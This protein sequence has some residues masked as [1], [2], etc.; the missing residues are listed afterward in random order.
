MFDAGSLIGRNGR[1]SNL[2]NAKQRLGA[3]AEALRWREGRPASLA[4]VGHAGFTPRLLL[5]VE[6]LENQR[7][8][9]RGMKRT[10]VKRIANEMSPTG[11][12]PNHPNSILS[13]NSSAA[14]K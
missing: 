1:K 2:L 9:K 13:A 7:P 12:P 4:A 5:A 11:A 14:T 6:S 10:P 3:K 8:A